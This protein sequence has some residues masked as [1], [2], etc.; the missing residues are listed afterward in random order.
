MAEINENMQT[1]NIDQLNKDARDIF[2]KEH[3]FKDTFSTIIATLNG[4]LDESEGSESDIKRK[5]KEVTDALIAHTSG[6]ND[7]TVETTN[8]IA[9]LLEE[10]RNVDSAHERIYHKILSD[11]RIINANIEN[12]INTYDIAASYYTD[13]KNSI[14]KTFGG[15]SPYKE[16]LI[17]GENDKWTVKAPG[18]TVLLRDADTHDRM[19]SFP[20]VID[21]NISQDTYIKLASFNPLRR[22]GDDSPVFLAEII[23]SGGLYSFKGYLESADIDRAG[24]RGAVFDAEYGISLEIPFSFKVVYEQ[25]SNTVAILFKYEVTPSKFTSIIKLDFSIHLLA[26]KN[27]VIEELNTEFPEALLP[28]V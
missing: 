3:E 16:G 1:P 8:K 10:L 19:V 11:I 17:G 28:A 4:I 12:R 20:V 14:F 18:S 13:L 23:I 5:K 22:K 27:L 15:K 25:E 9:L 26:G 24:K 2:Y 6:M 21:P 7:V